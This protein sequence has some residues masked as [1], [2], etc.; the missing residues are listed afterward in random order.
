MPPP[1]KVNAEIQT[2]RAIV[3]PSARY[4]SAWNE[5]NV[6]ISQRQRLISIYTT[7]ALAASGASLVPNLASIA[8]RVAYA[9]PPLSLLFIFLL[10]MHEQQIAILRSFLC[11]LESLP[12]S[13][14][15][16]QFYHT[17]SVRGRIAQEA[18]RVHDHVCFGLIL[19]FTVVAAVVWGIA[20][21]RCH[22]T[23]TDMVFTGVLLACTGLSLWLT[24][25]IP[26]LR[27]EAFRKS[28]AE[29]GA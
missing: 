2:P 6:R 18:R 21:S 17:Q 4:I 28:T 9:I 13:S 3:E 27:D 19:G 16:P 25:R 22:I 12:G 29:N 15:I 10:R 23:V 7:L 1:T 14:R 20:F 5:I 8:W 26:N 24:Y 11:E